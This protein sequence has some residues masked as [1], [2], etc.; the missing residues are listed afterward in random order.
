MSKT[1]REILKG[2][3]AAGLKNAELVEGG[4]HM[5]LLGTL[6]N[7]PIVIVNVACTSPND[8]LA[9]RKAHDTVRRMRR[10]NLTRACWNC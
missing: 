1:T 3:E 10:R 9:F 4:K 5:Q 2:A 7:V 8:H 6:D